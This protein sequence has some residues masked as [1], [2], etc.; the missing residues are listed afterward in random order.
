MEIVDRLP[1]FPLIPTQ[2]GLLQPPCALCGHSYDEHEWDVHNSDLGPWLGPDVRPGDP[3]F[4]YE[5]TCYGC[6]CL[7]IHP[8][9]T[10][11]EIEHEIKDLERSRHVSYIVKPTLVQTGPNTWEWTWPT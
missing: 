6:L 2:R 10:Q 3:I 7:G 8:S 4:P 11:A 1:Q 9:E 5:L